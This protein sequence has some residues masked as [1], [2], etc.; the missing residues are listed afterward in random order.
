MALFGSRQSSGE[1]EG[2]PIWIKY[3]LT[4][5]P[6]SVLA[7]KLNGAVETQCYPL[8]RATWDRGIKARICKWGV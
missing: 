8:K 3:E 1:Q 6:V 5:A 7:S 4:I 2:F